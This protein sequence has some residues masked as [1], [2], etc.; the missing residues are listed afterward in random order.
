MN[1]V[2]QVESTLQFGDSGVC[3]YPYLIVQL[4]TWNNTLHKTRLFSIDTD[5]ISGHSPGSVQTS[6]N[7]AKELGW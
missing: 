1:N 7:T 3:S 6:D 5:S 2:G 4:P